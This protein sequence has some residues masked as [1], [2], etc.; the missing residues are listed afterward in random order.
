MQHGTPDSAQLVSSGVTSS[1]SLN[2]LNLPGSLIT[3]DTPYNQGPN[4]QDAVENLLN[5]KIDAHVYDENT[6]I[7]PAHSHSYSSDSASSYEVPIKEYSNPLLIHN[8][9][10]KIIDKTKRNSAYEYDNAAHSSEYNRN[11]SSSVGYEMDT[12]M[13][14][15]EEEARHVKLQRVYPFSINVFAFVLYCFVLYYFLIVCVCMDIEES[16]QAPLQ[17]LHL[18]ALVPSSQMSTLQNSLTSHM[19]PQMALQ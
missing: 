6:Q 11:R 3:P 13:G 17:L 5:M 19:I 9:D 8:D 14:K 12:G 16:H 7:S 10:Q 4:T 15:T 1:S 18:K 2:N